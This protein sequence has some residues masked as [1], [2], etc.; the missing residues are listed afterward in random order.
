M[1]RK[2]SWKQELERIE[3]ELLEKS[4]ERKHR[5]AC[6]C[7]ERRDSFGQLTPCDGLERALEDAE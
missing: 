5:E 7:L 4:I 3:R 1:N 6:D 2:Q